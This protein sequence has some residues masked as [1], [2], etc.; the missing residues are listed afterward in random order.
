MSGAGSSRHEGNVDGDFT[1]ETIATYD[2]SYPD[3]D[4]DVDKQEED[5]KG[6]AVIVPQYEYGVITS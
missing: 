2:H 5:L 3:L 4:Y 1:E 6:S